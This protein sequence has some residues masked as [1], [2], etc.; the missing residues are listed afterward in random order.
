MKPVN[1]LNAQTRIVRPVLA[2]AALQHHGKVF[3]I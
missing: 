2:L 3:F 1:V